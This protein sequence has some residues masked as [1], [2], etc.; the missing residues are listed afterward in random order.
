MW[1][2]KSGFGRGLWPQTPT[3]CDLTIPMVSVGGGCRN[4]GCCWI[5]RSVGQ[6][7]V[8]AYKSK[9]GQRKDALDDQHALSPISQHAAVFRR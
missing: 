8:Q 7:L 9:Y 3:P 1:S 2:D 5:F 6:V 4:F